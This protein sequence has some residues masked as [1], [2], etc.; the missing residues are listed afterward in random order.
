[1]EGTQKTTY[2][3]DVEQPELA[4]RVSYIGNIP[5]QRGGV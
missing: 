3:V 5:L 4:N 2:M 1:M